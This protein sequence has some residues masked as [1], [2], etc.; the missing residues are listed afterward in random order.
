MEQEAEQ[1]QNQPREGDKTGRTWGTFCHLGAL[2]LYIG[3]PFGN[4]LVPLVIWLLKKD[5]LPLVNEHGKQSLNFQLSFTIYVILAVFAYFILLMTAFLVA[6][7]PTPRALL[8]IIPFLFA[9]FIVSHLVLTIAA[10]IKAGEGTAYRYPL[11]IR[12]FK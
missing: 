12:F 10:A 6:G 8:I 7:G 11:S 1:A 3:V 5:E 4:I 2:S 9:F